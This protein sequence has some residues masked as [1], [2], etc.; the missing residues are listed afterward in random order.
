MKLS[1]LKERLWRKERGGKANHW[2]EEE[3]WAIKVTGQRREVSKSK[4]GREV[5]KRVTSQIK[6]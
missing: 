4:G 3:R 5:G 6:N 2:S 1:P